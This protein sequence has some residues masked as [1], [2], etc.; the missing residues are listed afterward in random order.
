AVPLPIQLPIGSEEKFRGIVDLLEQKAWMFNAN[1]DM[2]P[3]ETPVPELM[4]AEVNEAR[5]NLIE[6]LGESDDQIME[7]YLNGSEISVEELKAAVR[8][9]TIAN[10]C[11][12]ILCGTALKN[13]GIQKLLNAVVDYLPSPLDVPPVYAIDPKT[14]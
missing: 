3:E 8:R 5:Q 13:K 10:K 7:A 4:L 14:S 1:P 2:Q 11:V 12:P 9:V 6:R